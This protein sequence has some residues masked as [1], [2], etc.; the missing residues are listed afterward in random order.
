MNCEVPSRNPCM[1]NACKCQNQHESIQ[2]HS[3]THH[4][5]SKTEYQKN[6]IPSETVSGPAGCFFSCFR[7]CLVLVLDLVF[8]IFLVACVGLVILV[9]VVAVLVVIAVIVLLIVLVV[10]AFLVVFAACVVLDAVK[11]FAIVLGLAS[12]QC[13]CSSLPIS[14][15]SRN[16]AK[17]EAITS[18]D[19]KVATVVW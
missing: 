2:N 11:A 1:F 4:T 7:P 5:F 12:L 3:A 13:C 6:A 18:A 19:V 9:T 17:A 8:L 16:R 10:L 15:S 14:S